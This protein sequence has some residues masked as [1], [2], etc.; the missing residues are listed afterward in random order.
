MNIYKGVRFLGVGG[1]GGSICRRTGVHSP[2][3]YI[4]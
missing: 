4:M 2:R 3:V 1:E